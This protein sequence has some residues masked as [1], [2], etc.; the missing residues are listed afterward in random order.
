MRK[1]RI[2]VFSAGIVSV[3][4]I[5]IYDVFRIFGYCRQYVKRLLGTYPAQ[6]LCSLPMV[7]LIAIACLVL[8]A[9]AASTTPPGTTATP[10]TS[11]PP[12]ETTTTS[13]SP[14]EP[15]SPCLEGDQPFAAG[16]VIPAFGSSTGDAAQ[17]SGIRAASHSGCERVVIDLLTADGAPAGSVGL[18]GI[19][20]DAVV[21]I[22]RVNLP[23]A[24]TKTAVADIRID[25]E[26]ADGA[27]V[28]RTIDGR[29]AVDIHVTAGAGIALRAFEI[30][31]P[32]R[33]VVDLR[34]DAGAPPVR[35]ALTGDRTVVV[36]PTF[37]PVT[38]PLIV[39]G[40]ARTAGGAIVV[41]IHES[42]DAPSLVE[43]T[44]PPSPARD[45]WEEYRVTQRDI[46][47]GPFELFVGSAP[48]GGGP[49]TGLWLSVGI[50]ETPADP[51]D[52]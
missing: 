11:L 40:Y 42:R 49:P 17:V 21:G 33:V 24:V 35:G 5:S 36:T 32:S 41:R 9:C 1:V 25:G 15:A 6:S 38:P 7:R 3:I 30:D 14:P 18:V 22:I 28:V 37:G 39:S 12:P 52:T 45:A 51:A 31:A 47:E 34:P 2:V 43:T 50:P 16:G 48:P 19:D 46:P 26:L 20:Y 29:L 44:V 4:T 27:F 13:T 8:S 23:P 10:V